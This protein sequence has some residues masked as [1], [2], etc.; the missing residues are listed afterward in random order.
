MA[1][2]GS[3]AI[4]V[5]F[6]TSTSLVAERDGV[7]RA[8]VLPLGF[9]MRTRFLPSVAALRG[10]RLALAED[11]ESRRGGDGV[12][13]SIKRAITEELETVPVPMADG[14]RPTRVHDVTLGL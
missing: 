3:R 11:A 13:R 12:I 8:E 9:E 4:G 6:G 7:E 5:D 1:G 10:G 2:D 14:I